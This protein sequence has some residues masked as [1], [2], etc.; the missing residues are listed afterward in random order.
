[1]KRIL[2]IFLVLFCSQIVVAQND[3]IDWATDLEYIKYELPKKHY[4]LFFQQSETDFNNQID[5]LIDLAPN[6]TTYQ[7]LDN[8]SQIIA[9]IGDSHTNMNYGYLNKAEEILPFSL[10]WFSDG[11]FITHS[12]INSKGLL[13]QKLISI[14][15]YP[16]QQIVDSLS[17]LIVI[18]N[19]STIKNTIPQMIGFVPHLEFFGFVINDSITAISETESGERIRTVFDKKLLKKEKIVRYDPDSIAFC[20]SNRNLFFTHDYFEQD[21]I[22]YIQYNYCWGKELEKIFG[23]RKRAKSFPSFSKFQK[24]VFKQIESY[25]MNKIIFDLRFNVGG[26]SLQGTLFIKKLAQYNSI[27]QRDRLFVV[28]GKHTFSSGI[29]NVM[30]FKE[31]TNATFIGEITTGRPNHYGEIKYLTLPSSGL[32]IS[33]STKYFDNYKPDTDAFYPDFEIGTSFQDY[34]KGIDPVFEYIRNM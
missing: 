20:W 25:P 9:K 11:I 29:I 21:S 5:K 18:D 19:E 28:T 24:D 2:K 26:S 16:I 31:N 6:L 22:L 4:D 10:Y 34:Q 23:S 12:R 13:G 7:I 14:N 8:L 3:T 15:G 33:Y 17:T 32:K 27:N 1:M 30:D